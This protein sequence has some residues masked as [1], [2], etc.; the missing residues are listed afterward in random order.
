MYRPDRPEGVAR[1]YAGGEPAPVPPLLHADEE[2]D[3]AAWPVHV[4]PDPYAL[5]VGVMCTY[6]QVPD[7]E[8]T[9][10]PTPLELLATLS[11]LGSAE[12][13]LV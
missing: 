3:N 6:R 11:V 8:C 4:V 10:K 13:P 9:A 1:A 2:A 12:A 5:P 7:A